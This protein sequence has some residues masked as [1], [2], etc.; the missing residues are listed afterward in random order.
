MSED[1]V[2]AIE[3]R[4]TSCDNDVFSENFIS[5][6]H[7]HFRSPVPVQSCDQEDMVNSELQEAAH[8]KHSV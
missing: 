4:R 5:L 6:M 3:A 7:P 1:D 2:A 8:R